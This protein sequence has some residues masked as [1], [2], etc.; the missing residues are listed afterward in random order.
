MTLH[1]PSFSLSVDFTH[2]TRNRYDDRRGWFY[3]ISQNILIWLSLK[4]NLSFKY[5]KHRWHRRRGLSRAQVVSVWRREPRVQ[6]YSTVYS[7]QCTEPVLCPAEAVCRR[8]REPGTWPWSN[9]WPGP[10]TQGLRGLGGAR[11]GLELSTWNHLHLNNLQCFSQIC[12]HI[13]AQIWAAHTMNMAWKDLNPFKKPDMT[14]AGSSFL[15]DLTL[16]FDLDK[17]QNKCLP[18]HWRRFY[19]CLLVLFQCSIWYSIL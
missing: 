10:R 9:R 14:A 18:L 15:F 3:W 8:R 6:V 7:V 19:L 17:S 11:S 12:I 1:N 13:H 2:R 4:S 5:M 16:R